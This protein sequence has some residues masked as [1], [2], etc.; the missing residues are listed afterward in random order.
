MTDWP[1]LRLFLALHRGGSVTSAARRLAT[2]VSTVSRH[3]DALEASLGQVLFLRGPDGLTPTEAAE[4]LLPLASEVEVRMARIAETVRPDV[5]EP[6]GIVR[7][8]TSADLAQTILLPSLPSL[9]ARHPRLRLELHVGTELSDLA[10]READ[11]AVRI[12]TPGPGADLVVRPLRVTAW[13]V[14]GSRAYLATHPATLPL[15]EHVWVDQTDEWAQTPAVAW[16]RTHAPAATRLLRTGDL[17]T[18]RL[19]VAAGLGL[20]VLPDTLGAT[21]PGLVAL[22]VPVDIPGAPLVLV[23]HR[24]T[25]RLAGVRAVWDFVEELLGQRDDRP[26]QEELDLLRGRLR[27]YFGW[28]FPEDP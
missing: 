10:R 23:A 5:G 6:E 26:E 4:R 17:T 19:A 2:T 14:F 11:L 21:T 16:L 13:R 25:R 1:D 20:G 8:A 22:D 3:L 12:G 7:L 9:L 24:D 15:G 27:D 28:R 18:G